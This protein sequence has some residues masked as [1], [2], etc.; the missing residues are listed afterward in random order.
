MSWAVDS[1]KFHQSV[2]VLRLATAEA[3][4]KE[5]ECILRETLRPERD[6]MKHVRC[7]DVQSRGGPHGTDRGTGRVARS[8][9]CVK[10]TLQLD[11][12]VVDLGRTTS[13]S[14]GTSPHTPMRQKSWAVTV[15][16]QTRQHTTVGCLFL[17]GETVTQSMMTR[18]EEAGHCAP[19]KVEPLWAYSSDINKKH[20]ELRHGAEHDSIE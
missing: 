8:K 17:F 14:F 16:F 18:L 3:G 5:K 2:T 7:R 9:W 10:W 15:P 1:K 12:R 11:K 6:R 13:F 20:R 4:L 19:G